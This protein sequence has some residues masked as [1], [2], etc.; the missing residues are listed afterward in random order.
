M[1]P[2]TLLKFLS[3][4]PCIGSDIVNKVIEFFPHVS[5]TALDATR[6]EEVQDVDVHGFYDDDDDDDDDDDNNDDDDDDDD[7]DG[8]AAADDDDE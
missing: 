2:L 6:D 3:S 8:D 4:L 5:S 1:I 7:Y